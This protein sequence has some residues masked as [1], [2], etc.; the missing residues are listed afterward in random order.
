MSKYKLKEEP[1]VADP[2]DD[3]MVKKE[4][5]LSRVKFAMQHAYTYLERNGRPQAPERI[6]DYV[7]KYAQ[8]FHQYPSIGK[9]ISY[10][11][12]QEIKDKYQRNRSEWTETNS[13]QL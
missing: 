6:T 13:Q 4:Q 7:T 3:Y 10:F 8:K 5:L 2:L 12:S 1:K 11:T 9:I